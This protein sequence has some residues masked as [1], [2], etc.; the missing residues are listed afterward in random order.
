M[1]ILKFFVKLDSFSD[2]KLSE[3]PSNTILLWCAIKC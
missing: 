3:I 2:K 1:I